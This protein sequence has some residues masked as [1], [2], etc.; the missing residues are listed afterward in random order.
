MQFQFSDRPSSKIVNVDNTVSIPNKPYTIFPTDFTVTV[1]IVDI[2]LE[3]SGGTMSHQL[4][5]DEEILRDCDETKPKPAVEST[6]VFRTN[7][8]PFLPIFFMIQFFMQNSNE[9][10]SVNT[11]EYDRFILS[12]RVVPGGNKKMRDKK[13]NKMHVV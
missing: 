13:I 6:K 8:A 9:I 12:Q 4:R 7:A 1:S 3:C 5:T 11:C 10:D 2:P